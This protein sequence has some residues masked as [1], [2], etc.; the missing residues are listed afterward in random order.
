MGVKLTDISPLASMIKGEGVAKYMGA[1]PAAITKR[2]GRRKD[3]KEEDR[4]AKEE[5]EK[6]R[7]E[8]VMAGDA[9]GMKAGGRVKNIDGKALRGRTRGRIV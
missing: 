2:R 6:A 3:K 1:I 5:A 8:I 4:R 7:L 9:Q